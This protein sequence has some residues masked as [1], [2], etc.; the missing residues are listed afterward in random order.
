MEFKGFPLDLME[1]VRAATYELGMVKF[2]SFDLIGR[3]YL[4]NG[5]RRSKDV[6]KH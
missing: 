4:I 5:G 2:P 6:D 1:Q 3:R